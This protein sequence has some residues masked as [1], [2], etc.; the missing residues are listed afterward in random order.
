MP[1]LFRKPLQVLK[2]ID[3]TVQSNC[4]HCGEACRSQK[5]SIEDKYFCCSGC[6]MV[7]EIL[8]RNELC[9]YYDLNSKP[10]IKVELREGKFDFLDDPQIAA[11][12]IRFTDGRQT[13]VSF[14]LPR[15]HCSSCLWLLEHINAVNS[16]ILSSRVDFSAKEVAI[17]FDRQQTTLR[18]VVETLCAVGYEPHISLQQVQAQQ[19]V[20]APTGKLFRLGIAG[21]CFVNIMMLSFPEYFAIGGYLEQEVGAALHYFIVAL[22]LPV[23]FYCASGFFRSAWS[24]LRNGFLN[25]DLPVALAL[26]ITFLRSLYE[27]FSHTGT[28]YLD[29]MS[30]IVFFMLLGRLVQDRTYRALSFDRDFRSFFPLAVQA[31]REAH[32]K[33]VM[34][35]ELKPDDVIRIR[36]GELIPVDAILSKGTATIDYS[37]VSG[38]SLPV[39]KS[40]GEI[41]YAGG[42]QLSGAIELLVTRE[43]S[44]SYLTGLWNRDIFKQQKK[45]VSGIHSLGKHFTLLVLGIGATAAGY[46]LAHGENRL[47]WNALTTI[48]IVACPCALLLSATFTNG[49]ILRILGK[50]GLYLRHPDVIEDMAGIGH[51]VFDKTGT[52][53]ENEKRTVA[54][55]GRTLSEE[56]RD[57]IA[58]LLAQSNH[59]LSRAVYEYLDRHTPAP[60]ASYREV[61]G[62]GI[63]GWVQERHVKIGAAGFVQTPVV[64][65]E[66]EVSG[67]RVYCCIDGAVAGVFRVQ[68]AYRKGWPQVIQ[69][70]KGRFA[71]SVLSGDNDG[72]HTYLQGLMGKG[73][74]LLFNRQPEQKLEYIRQLQEQE[75]KQVLMMG[76]GLND[77]GA[78]RQSAVGIAIS[79]SSNNFTPAS[80]GMLDAACFDRL[81]QFLAFARD[82]QR[83]IRAS[84]ILSLVYNIIGLWYAVQGILSPLV[85]AILMP[86]SSLSIILLTYGLSEWAARK[87]NL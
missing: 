87:N 41:I 24:G 9:A 1:L 66:S 5:I 15:M 86:A 19:G 85:A 43:V 82:S 79:G 44:Q 51:I 73:A 17:V 32:F 75:H 12:L 20:K 16:G 52:I 13:H 26:A 21:F 76:D 25:I 22:S 46:W 49:N 10:G 50:R 60:V 68:H 69:Q 34:V 67:S 30:G 18:A 61:P 29:S 2:T 31:L 77:A 78:L 28:G 4:Y 42:K 48:L 11:P 14:Y 40:V 35:Q 7:Y 72:E 55:E 58:A 81:P 80:D 3:H 8:N 84:F 39:T 70:L 33:P 57:S 83:I 54:Y 64:E 53:T 63:E 37:F 56:E 27:L 36:A 65:R 45:S 47:A 38:E 71:L 59:P 62:Q 74:S 6:K 23:I